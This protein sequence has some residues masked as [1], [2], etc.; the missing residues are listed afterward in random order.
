[1]KDEKLKIG[2]KGGLKKVVDM[3]KEIRRQ[4][5]PKEVFEIVDGHYE[6]TQKSKHQKKI[7]KPS[8]DLET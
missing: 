7:A 2:K 1:M 6:E 8:S 3:L 4:P 5:L